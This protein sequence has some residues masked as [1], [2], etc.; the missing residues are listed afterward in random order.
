MRVAI[1]LSS[2][3]PTKVSV[4]YSRDYSRNLKKLHTE[5]ILRYTQF[6]K[7]AGGKDLVNELLFR[8]MHDIFFA[9]WN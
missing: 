2:I 8:N 6:K 1:L 7:D 3:P 4:Y 5:T 9:V